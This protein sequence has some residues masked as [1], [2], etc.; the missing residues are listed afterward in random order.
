MMN[1]GPNIIV[2]DLVGEA[3]TVQI[4]SDLGARRQHMAWC[5]CSERVPLDAWIDRVHHQSV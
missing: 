3:L 1:A 2:G 5:I 4:S